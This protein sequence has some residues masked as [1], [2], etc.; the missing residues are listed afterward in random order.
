[1]NNPID[2]NELDA[3]LESCDS[4]WS[5][6]QAHGLLCGRLSVLGTDG[7]V[8]WL[9]QVL[10]GSNS[11]N[12]ARGECASMLEALFQSTWQQLTE[13]QSDFELLLP[14]DDEDTS[15]KAEAIGSWCEGFLHGLVTGQH[16]DEL[17][18][19]LADEPL[20][21]LIKDMLEITRATFDQGDDDETNEAAYAE[22]VEYI[23]VAA[24]LAY[25]ELAD[26]RNSGDKN[27]VSEAVSDALH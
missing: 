19:R 7:V 8:I 5:S 4:D 14:D 18:K 6:A 24:Q 25:E 15:R 20:A 10:E 2:H 3:V 11:N 26:F 16:A 23:R 1:M 9:D 12:E 22:L 17:K 27:A 13:R 21:S